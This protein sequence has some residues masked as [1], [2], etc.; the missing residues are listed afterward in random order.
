MCVCIHTYTY[1]YIYLYVCVCMYKK[2]RVSWSNNRNIKGPYHCVSS[3]AFLELGRW[4]SSWCIVGRDTG[5]QS[6]ECCLRFLQTLEQLLFA[7]HCSSTSGGL[8]GS[9]RFG[10]RC[11]RICKG[12]CPL[13]RNQKHVSCSLVGC[14]CVKWGWS[15]ISF[16]LSEFGE[17]DLGCLVDQD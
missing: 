17:Y 10:T 13:Q 11:R 3:G 12:R 9:A 14:V 1:V 16:H 6:D 4:K 8:A 15:H 7:S 2:S 5:W